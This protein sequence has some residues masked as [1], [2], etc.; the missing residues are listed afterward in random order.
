MTTDTTLITAFRNE[1]VT[2][3]QIDEL[4]GIIKG[5]LADGMVS[6]GEVEFL[7]SWMEVN[8]RAANLWPAK[9]LYPRLLAVMADGK[10]D[11]E[12]ESEI[13]ELLTKTVGGNTAL[14]H[15]NA[16]DSTRL[17]FTEPALPIQFAGQLFCFTGKFNSGL[18]T[19]CEQQVTDRGGIASGTITKKLNYLVIGDI[20]NDN[21]LHS[22]HGRKIEK[23]IEYNAAGGNIFIVGE[24]HWHGHLWA[25]KS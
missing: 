9:V 5:V 8:R 10:L 16:S 1:A 11:L 3:R 4:I 19:W 21:W 18:R 12:E 6:Q 25:A 13:L 7:I 15:G 2:D 22:T 24:E 23:A 14:Q 20:G 17:P